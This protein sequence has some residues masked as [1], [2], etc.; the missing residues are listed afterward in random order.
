MRSYKGG[1]KKGDTVMVIAGGNSK[2]RPL[3]GQVGKILRFSDDGERVVVEGLNIVT[4]YKK[5]TS[6]RQ[7]GG[8]VQVEAPVSISNVMFYAEKAKK[9]VRI[10]TKTLED[11]KKVRG[12][13]DPSSKEFVQID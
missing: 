3:K 8:R 7:Q 2:T 13:T 12:Y 4:K 9:P 5:P 6:M 1:L 10:K 11:G